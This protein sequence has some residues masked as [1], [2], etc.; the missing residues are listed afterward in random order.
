MKNEIRNIDELKGKTISDIKP[1]CGDL[2]L[3][4]SDN[5]FAV[6][7]V[8]DTTE[9]FGHTRNEVNIDKFGRGETDHMLV[10]LGIISK[11]EHEEACQREEEEYRKRQEVKDR[12]ERERTENIELEQLEKLKF[13]YGL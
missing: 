10:D 2:W 3:K 11:E 9:G 13:K 1:N 12:L 6:L 7:V 8:N 5:T 4:F